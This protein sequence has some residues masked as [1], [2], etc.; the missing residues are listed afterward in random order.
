MIL[1]GYFI[2]H[3][4]PTL[5]ERMVDAMVEAAARRGAADEQASAAQD[6]SFLESLEEWSDFQVELES[7]EKI[8]CH[9]VTLAKWSPTLEAM[10]KTACVETQKG[11]I[12]IRGYDERTVKVFIEYLYQVK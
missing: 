7:G 6:M 12:K 9:K 1:A 10:L 4:K 8:K 2:S 3:I 5:A 11:E